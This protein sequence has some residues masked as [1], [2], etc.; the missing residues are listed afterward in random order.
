MIL[1]KFFRKTLL[2][3]YATRLLKGTIFLLTILVTISSRDMSNRHIITYIALA[4]VAMVL[5]DV[6]ATVIGDQIRTRRAKSAEEIRDMVSE[7]LPQFVP[8]IVGIA[9]FAFAASHLLTN[10]EAFELMEGGCVLLMIIFCY[11]SQRFSGRRG[12][13]AVWPTTIAALF[14]VSFVLLRGLISAMPSA[15]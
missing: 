15:Q 11:F 1:W 9:I 8:G 12:W 10:N 13:K 5:T 6:Y 14:G 4:Y 3:V 7:F 2:G